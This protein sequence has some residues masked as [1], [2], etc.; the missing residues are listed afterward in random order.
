[1]IFIGSTVIFGQGTPGPEAPVGWPNR[2]LMITYCIWLIVFAWQAL[3]VRKPLRR[4]PS[5]LSSS[6]STGQRQQPTVEG[7]SR[8]P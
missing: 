8:H 4:S 2:L 5:A 6:T 3:R 7:L 1:V